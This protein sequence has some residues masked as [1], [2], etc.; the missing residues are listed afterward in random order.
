MI[1]KDDYFA[2]LDDD[3]T[4]QRMESTQRAAIDLKHIQDAWV[5]HQLKDAKGLRILEIGGGYLRALRT[6]AAH[7]EIWNLDDFGDDAGSI[8]QGRKVPTPTDWKLVRGKLGTFV[9]DLAGEYFDVVVSISVVEHVHGADAQDLFWRDHARVM[10][11]GAIAYH[12][13]DF[14]V[15][16]EPEVHTEDR[17]DLLLRSFES[18]GLKLREPVE[19]ERPLRFRSRYASN[20]DYGMW[21]WNKAVPRLALRRSYSQS[22]SLGVVLE[23]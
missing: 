17:L 1:T 14:Y 22:V 13:I 3:V 23:K 10:K 5:L 4:R 2:A 12:A 21:L 19:I 7:N 15:A 11:T 18:A 9:S 20:T 6:I 16:D 8:R